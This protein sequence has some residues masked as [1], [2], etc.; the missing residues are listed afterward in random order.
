M[1]HLYLNIN[2]DTSCEIVTSLDTAYEE[3]PT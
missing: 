1:N 2:H 3:K